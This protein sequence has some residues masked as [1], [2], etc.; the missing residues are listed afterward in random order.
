[1]KKKENFIRYRIIFPIKLLFC[2]EFLKFNKF[3]KPNGQWLRLKHI[4]LINNPFNTLLNLKQ[5][6]Y[7]NSQSFKINKINCI[8]LLNNKFN[9]NPNNK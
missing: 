5:F 8:L 9:N 1:M 6:N 2:K 7:N 3:H 4:S